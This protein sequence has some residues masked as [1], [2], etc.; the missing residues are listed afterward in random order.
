MQIPPMPNYNAH[1][2]S[3]CSQKYANMHGRKRLYVHGIEFKTE[4]V[5]V[6]SV[7]DFVVTHEGGIMYNYQIRSELQLLIADDRLDYESFTSLN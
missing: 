3:G 5:P 6:L 2:L 7:F 1:W 4:I